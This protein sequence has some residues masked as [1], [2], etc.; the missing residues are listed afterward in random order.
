[1]RNTQST[2]GCKFYIIRIL[3][4]MRIFNKEKCIRLFTLTLLMIK[5]LVMANTANSAPFYGVDVDLHNVGIEV[6]VNDIPAYFDEEKGQ[7][8]VE[9]PVPES[10]IDGINS[11]SLSIFLPYDGDE[12][13]TKYEKNAYATV[14]LFSQDLSTKNTPKIKL[15]SITLKISE[16]KILTIVEDFVSKKRATPSSEMADDKSVFAQVETKITSPFSRWAWQD[17]QTIENNKRNFDTLLA[18]YKELHATFKSKNIQALKNSYSLRA[19]E[20][21]IAYSLVD[22]KEGQKKLST[23]KDMMDKSLELYDFHTDGMRLEIIGNGKLARISDADHDQPIL[24][25][26]PKTNLLHLYKFMFYL[27]KNNQW[28]MV[29]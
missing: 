14:T 25:F 24:Y 15:T 11:L 19:K 9:I 28:I 1:M 10:I 3:T 29:R 6:K 22:E 2:L 16:K 23:G 8:T 26:E 21:A 12:R 17:G 20:I 5:G 13:T 4:T 18:V 7:L 27:D